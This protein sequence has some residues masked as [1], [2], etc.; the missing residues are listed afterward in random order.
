MGNWHDVDEP[1]EATGQVFILPRVDRCVTARRVLLMGPAAA[2]V[3]IEGKDSQA[4]WLVLYQG[5]FTTAPVPVPRRYTMVR[6]QSGGVAVL[7]QLQHRVAD[8][9]CG[10]P[11]EEG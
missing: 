6:A 9:R 10:C 1:R 7:Y 5:P 8:N 2:V 11:G 3:N 4:N